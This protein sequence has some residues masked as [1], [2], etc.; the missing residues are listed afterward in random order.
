MFKNKI[1]PRT[2]LS[3]LWIFILFNMLLRD[4]H[5]FPTDG[6]VEKM[7]SLKLSEEVMLFYAFIVE[8]PIMMVVL[9][10]IL[11]DKANKWANI[12]AVIVSSLGILYTIPSGHMDEIFFA[13]VNLAAFVVIILT[14]WKL[15]SLDS[16]QKLNSVEKTASRALS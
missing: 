16:S 7:M 10:R 12:I 14:A 9:S 3:T 15:T 1:K 6:Y 13:I 2:L 8:I 4:L 5:E 11:N